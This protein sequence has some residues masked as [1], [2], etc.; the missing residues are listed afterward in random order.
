MLVAL[1]FSLTFLAGVPLLLSSAQRFCR[2]FCL[3][4]RVRNLVP[5]LTSHP[6]VSLVE[7]RELAKSCCSS[8]FFS[9][10]LSLS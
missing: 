6:E 5:S 1:L 2:I 8:C 9:P 10:T 7:R 3:L 4:L